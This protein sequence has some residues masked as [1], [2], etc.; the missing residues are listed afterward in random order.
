[1]YTFLSFIDNIFID[2]NSLPIEILYETE[3]NSAIIE[4]VNEKSVES[5]GNQLDLTTFENNE[6]GINFFFFFIIHFCKFVLD[7]N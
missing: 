3:F 2:I 4:T 5:E 1:M 6:P 7:L